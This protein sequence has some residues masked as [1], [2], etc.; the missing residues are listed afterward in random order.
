M[1]LGLALLGFC[2][3]TLDKSPT[4]S[5]SL[6]WGSDDVYRARH[7]V[8]DSTSRARCHLGA[9]QVRG[10]TSR[11]ASLRAAASPPVVVGWLLQN[12]GFRG[13]LASEDQEAAGGGGEV[14]GIAF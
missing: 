11:L 14:V 1:G 6:S 12:R 8:T 10:E 9:G 13:G 7:A 3:V 2:S 4:L 5:E